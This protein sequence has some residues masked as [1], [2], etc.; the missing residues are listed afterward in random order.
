MQ[1]N[2]VKTEEKG[3]TEPGYCEKTHRLKMKKT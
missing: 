3:P 2:G 1:I